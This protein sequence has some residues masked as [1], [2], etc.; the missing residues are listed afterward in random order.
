MYGWPPGKYFLTFVAIFR[1]PVNSLSVS[2]MHMMMCKSY[3][4]VVGRHKP[5][6]IKGLKYLGIF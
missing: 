2:I 1:L 6:I 4:I 3:K 5:L